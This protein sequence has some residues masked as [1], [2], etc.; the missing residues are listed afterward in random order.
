MLVDAGLDTQGALK[1][2]RGS[3]LLPAYP[4]GF[5]TPL[6]FVRNL[7]THYSIES[8]S[9][10]AVANHLSCMLATSA[11]QALVTNLEVDFLRRRQ[12]ATNVQTDN[13]RAFLMLTNLRRDLTNTHEHMARTSSSVDF[14]SAFS[15]S[16]AYRA[17]EPPPAQFIAMPSDHS[18][19]SPRDG[20]APIASPVTGSRKSKQA[21]LSKL[22]ET[23]SELD[24]RLRAIIAALN[25]E[26]QIVIGSV[27][28]QD[29][30]AMKR[31]ADL[32]MQLTES[33]M[34]QTEVSIRQTRWT[35]AL[36]LLAAMY[37][38]MTLVTGIFGMNI[39]EITGGESPN[40]WWV[41]VI[42]VVTM[43]ITLGS[44]ARYAL[45]EWQWYRQGMHGPK[46]V[47][48]QYPINGIPGEQEHGMKES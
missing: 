2:I 24:A 13:E 27:Q 9:R 40:W 31:Q 48:K 41:I 19:S 17:Q 7:F 4:S 43:G 3:E 15:Q 30:K 10:L 1:L 26:I 38:P 36:A 12:M 47:A 46:A 28:I 33:T 29:A 25:D 6:D 22:S 39:K 16:D 34:R 20:T 8:I 23:F 5:V 44:V 45:V 14:V 37:L 35:V 42:W 11:Y 21:D 18:M 32:T